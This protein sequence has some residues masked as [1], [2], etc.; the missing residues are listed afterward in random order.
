[1]NYKAVIIKE[2]N[3]IYNT[4]NI[5][6]MNKMIDYLREN[7]FGYTYYPRKDTLE[8]MFINLIESQN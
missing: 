8:N 4:P 6:E 3:F 7:K 5:S 2:M 1:M